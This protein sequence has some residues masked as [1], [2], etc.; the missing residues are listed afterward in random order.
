MSVLKM[1]YCIVCKI[2]FEQRN[3]LERVCS[4]SCAIEYKNSLSTTIKKRKPIKKVSDKMAVN[5]REYKK[6][7][8]E[9]LALHPN[10]QANLKDCTKVATQIHHKKS[11][12]GSLLTDATHFLAVC[13]SCHHYIELHP[14]EAK[15]LKLSLDRF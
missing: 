12:I 13:H 11:R 2:P 15:K 9:F 8:V 10:C 14:I 5:L 4:M 6:V 7:R 1:K 3:S